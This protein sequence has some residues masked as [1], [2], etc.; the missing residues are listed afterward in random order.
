MTKKIIDSKFLYEIVIENN[1]VEGNL[2]SQS[3]AAFYI[4][5]KNSS[6]HINITNNIF[7]ENVITLNNKN[8]FGSMVHLDNP[9]YI[10][11]L[12]NI[13]R[14][15]KGILGSCVYLKEDYSVFSFHANI[16]NNTFLNNYALLGAAG[17]Y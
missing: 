6:T 4:D 11:I 13:F 12:G 3:G 5:N 14:S 9:G 17:Y 15:N 8:L 2:A 1:T 16:K 10:N 7:L